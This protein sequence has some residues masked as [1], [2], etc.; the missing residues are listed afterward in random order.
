MEDEF[1]GVENAFKTLEDSCIPNMVDEHMIMCTNCDSIINTSMCKEKNIVEGCCPVCK[2]NDQ[3]DYI[4]SQ[5]CYA[6]Q[7]RRLSLLFSKIGK[8]NQIK[9]TKRALISYHGLKN[10]P[11]FK[12]EGYKDA[13]RSMKDQV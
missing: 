8:R 6:E 12:Q 2:K 7:N 10:R 11:L 5:N 9:S 1:C 4:E 3:I 13:M